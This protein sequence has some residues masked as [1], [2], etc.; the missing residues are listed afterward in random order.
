MQG[1]NTWAIVVAALAAFVASSAWYIAFA[2]QR[3]Q[4]TSGG[5]TAGAV[6]RPDPAKMLAELLR[7]VVLAVVLAYLVTHVGVAGVAGAF[8]FGL[9][10][11]VGFPLILLTGSILWEHVPWKL[12]AIH[13]GDWLIK[14]LLITAI[15]TV[16]Q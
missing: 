12:A 4:L 3:A 2:Q 15:V 16:W 13:A 5:T 14:L 1:I 11:W 8:G 9:L 7:N 10:I 6:N